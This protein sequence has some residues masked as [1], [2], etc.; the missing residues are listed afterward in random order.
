MT[1]FEVGEQD[2]TLLQKL[3]VLDLEKKPQQK[4]RS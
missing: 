1:A 3:E 2:E 4:K